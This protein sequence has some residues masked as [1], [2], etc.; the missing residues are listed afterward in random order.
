MTANGDFNFMLQGQTE[1]GRGLPGGQS[2]QPRCVDGEPGR[3][4]RRPQGCD[5]T[6]P[7]EGEQL[8]SKVHWTPSTLS[9]S[10]IGDK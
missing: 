5:A 10:L 2:Q 3:T 6:L 4:K 8:Q 9:L 7:Q 1:G